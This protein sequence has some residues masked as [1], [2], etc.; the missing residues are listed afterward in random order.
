MRRIAPAARTVRRSRILAVSA[1]QVDGV[2]STGCRLGYARVRPRTPPPQDR[3]VPRRV[4]VPRRAAH[5]VH[6]D[7]ESAGSYWACCEPVCSRAQS[8]LQ[9]FIVPHSPWWYGRTW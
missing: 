4:Y 1:R 3:L 6:E 5:D 8:S 9:P 7:A 2:R